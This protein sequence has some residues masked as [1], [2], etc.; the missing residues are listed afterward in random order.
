MSVSD[1]LRNR[2]QLPPPVRRR[3]LR[4]LAQ[5]TLAELASE[6]GIV[7]TTLWAWEHGERTPRGVHHGLYLEA[8]SAIADEL[9]V[10]VGGGDA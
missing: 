4:E 1:H 6:I 7:V 3:E 9:G 10:R 5:L 2:Q 8:L